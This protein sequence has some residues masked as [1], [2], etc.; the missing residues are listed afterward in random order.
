MKNLKILGI[1]AFAFVLGL[2]VNNFAMSQ[3]PASYKEQI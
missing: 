1:V 2:G 3:S